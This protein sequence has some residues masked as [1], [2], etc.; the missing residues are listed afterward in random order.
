MRSGPLEFINRGA[1]LAY[2]KG[3]LDPQSQEPA[4]VVVRA[5]SGF[6][7]SSLIDRVRGEMDAPERRFCLVDPSIRATAGG[8]R[9]YDGFFL[10]KCAEALSDLA[11]DDKATWPSLSEF[12]KQRRWKTAAEKSAGDL[13]SELPSFE[14][15]YKVALDYAARLLGVGQHSP[16]ALLQSDQAQAVAV[17]GEYARFVLDGF[18]LVLV[19]REAQ[20]CDLESL[21]R[22]LSATRPSTGAAG[23]VFEYTSETGRF[24]PEHAKIFLEWG[25]TREG[26]DILDLVKLE[27]DHL[28]RLLRDNVSGDFALETEAWLAWDGNLRSIVELKFQVGVGRRAIGATAIAGVLE[29]VERGV[30]DHIRGLPVLERLILACVLAHTE[31]ID[32]H[33]L[34]QVVARLDPALRPGLFQRALD[35]LLGE[36]G[37]LARTDGALRLNDETVAHAAN[38][39]ASF[40]SLIALAEAALRDWYGELIAAGDYKSVGM[41]MAV[42]Q[43]FRLC[44]RTRDV[45]GLV[46]AS[47]VLIAEVRQAQDQLVYVDAVASAIAAD[48]ELYGQDH[49]DL[50]VWAAS[51]AYG[52]SDWG[53]VVDLLLAKSAQDSFS[54]LMRAFAMQEVGRHQEALDLAQEVAAHA[55]HDDE[56]LASELVAILI[57]GCMGDYDQARARLELLIADPA[58]Q[59]SPLL[60][61]AFRFFE[62]VD[63]FVDALPR[64]EQSIA[65]FDRFGF[66]KSRA[67][68]QLPAAMFLAR[69]GDVEAGRAMLAEASQDLVG[70]V[71]DQHMVLNNR[72]AVELLADDPDTRLCVA[73]L[74][75]AL[76]TARDDFSELT[77]IT[78]LAIAHARDDDLEAA[79]G[80]AE[81]ALRV[82][83]RHDFADQDTYWPVCFN[84]ARI[85]EAAG[86][87]DRAA[88]AWGF[89][90]AQGR[91]P[92]V[93]SDY[94]AFRYGERNVA[95]EPYG[96]LAS[97]AW[98]P[99][100]LS[101]WVIDLEGL[102]LLKRAR[103]R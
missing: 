77:I 51:L 49:D 39:I 1:E 22:L 67:Y 98:H 20:H 29:N 100:Y 68:S 87:Q 57:V 13:V 94:W 66:A 17:C 26:L 14:S 2:F 89:P 86:R 91:A 31:A 44:A 38:G 3:V 55:A 35:S 15:A 59:Q 83:E 82:L 5:P 11:A 6:G 65:W 88:E 79:M 4:L 84:A 32:R 69:L 23:L 18:A 99:L 70:E 102:D 101:H 60:G 78:N 73:W 37:F 52:V 95:P 34:Q 42:R 72:A 33:V 58:H 19:V 30:G 46:R 8:T 40:R 53:R 27:S 56:R 45:T 74:K 41:P 75:A 103:L 47:E 92:S 9:L 10:Q 76:T 93:N 25:E 96:F 36:H 21:R 80:C 7:K 24:A 71:R 50:L 28:Q 81:K 62:V 64:L 90:K 16:K 48:P 54:L 97:R 12:L 61:Y 43:L 85:F 63:G